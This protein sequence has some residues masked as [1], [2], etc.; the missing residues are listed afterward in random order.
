MRGRTS[1]FRASFVWLKAG[2]LSFDGIIT[3][4]FPLDE[5]NVALDMMRSGRSGRILLRIGS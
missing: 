4:E 1:T 2:R 3:H 5:I